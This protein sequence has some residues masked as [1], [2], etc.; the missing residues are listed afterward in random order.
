MIEVLENGSKEMESDGTRFLNVTFGEP[1]RIIVI[2]NQLQ[3]TLPRT[4]EMKVP[5]GRLVVK[6]TLI[7]ISTDKGKG[8]YF[9]D[10]SGK[11]IQTLRKTL[12]NLSEELSIP[13][14]QEP[15][16]YKD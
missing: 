10:A 8:W 4:I 12:P 13:E 3:C 7:A 2:K 14:N 5:D 11:D 15:T 16:F 9:V 1:S 6:S